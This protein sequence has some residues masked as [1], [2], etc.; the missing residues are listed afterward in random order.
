MLL[1]YPEQPSKS[2]P[3][4]EHAGKGGGMVGARLCAPHPPLPLPGR[5]RLASRPQPGWLGKSGTGKERGQRG[6]FGSCACARCQQSWCGAALQ[7]L[8][9]TRKSAAW[10]PGIE[11]VL[12]KQLSIH[13]QNH[14]EVIRLHSKTSGTKYTNIS[15]YK[16]NPWWDVTIRKTKKGRN[17]ASYQVP[18]LPACLLSDSGKIPWKFVISSSMSQIYLLLVCCFAKESVNFRSSPKIHIWR[19]DMLPH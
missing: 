1:N 4:G 2:G 11:Y 14:F 7:L 17:G 19:A 8:P 6:H 15:W 10:Q 18:G 3:Q 13:W 5:I 12:K 9:C 16:N